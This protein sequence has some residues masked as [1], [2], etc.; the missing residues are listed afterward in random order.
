MSCPVRPPGVT[1]V[2]RWR[3]RALTCACYAVLLV[4]RMAGAQPTA[5][6]DGPTSS[7]P[8][9]LS[10]DGNFLIVANAGKDSVS[11]FDLRGD[12][13]RKVATVP[14]Q[15]KPTSVALAPDGLGAYVAN[16]S[17]GTVSFIRLN[18]ARDVVLRPHKHLKVG[19][20]PT[21]LVLTPNGTRLYVANGRSNT[22]SV[23]DTLSERVIATI[24]VGLEP[25][26]LAVTNDGDDDD[27]DETLYVSSFLELDTSGNV[28]KRSGDR[29]GLV[30]I[31]STG[32]NAVVGTSYIDAVND[33]VR[34]KKKGR[35]AIGRPLVVRAR[36]G[37]SYSLI[38]AATAFSSLS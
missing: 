4:P 2:M 14:V 8:L 35:P 24:R 27:T 11:F 3:R 32:S 29:R 20:K 17:S 7:Q 37:G 10:A 1:A 31:I 12:T 18:I 19:L 15:S 34:E 5:R 9:A 22:V 16:T 26:G 13:I 36:R 33:V 6:F 23:V 28:E 30:T 21:S 38:D 25:R